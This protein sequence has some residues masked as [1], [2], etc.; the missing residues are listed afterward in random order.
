MGSLWNQIDIREYQYKP[1]LGHLSPAD[2]FPG[3]IHPVRVKVGDSSPNPNLNSNPRSNL[4]P[5]PNPRDRGITVLIP[6]I[7]ADSLHS[8]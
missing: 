5:S 7:P 8:M 4:N 6:Y 1:A 2:T 3:H